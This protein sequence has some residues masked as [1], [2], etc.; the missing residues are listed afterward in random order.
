MGESSPPELGWIRT[1]HGVLQETCR[2]STSGVRQKL[3]QPLTPAE[4]RMGS[5]LPYKNTYQYMKS[6]MS[7]TVHILARNNFIAQL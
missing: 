7:T 6:L 3:T 1:G 5:E 4:V 2:K